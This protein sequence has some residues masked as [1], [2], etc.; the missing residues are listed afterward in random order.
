MTHIIRRAPPNAVGLET[1]LLVHGLPRA[2]SHALAQRLARTIGE[3]GSTA[4]V[5]AIVSGQP[6][7]GLNE[8]ELGA[9]LDAQAV[10]K[11]STANL[12]VTIHRRAH[13]ATTVS[14]TVELAA[15]AGLRIIATGGIGGVHPGHAATID[16][17]ADLAAIARYPVAVVCSGVKTLLDVVSTRELLETLGV[18]VIG[19]G[20]DR[21]PAFYLRDGGCDV[22][23]RFDE[24]GD[25]ARFIAF[26]L[27]RTGRGILIAQP[28]PQTHEIAP[29]AMNA[30]MHEATQRAAAAGI[31]GRSLTPFILT[32][33]HE[34]SAGATLAANLALVESN[35]KLAA[36]IS[37]RQ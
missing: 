9:L 16:I 3:Q 18:P 1:T 15:R 13:G 33:L 28:V 25:L 30:W 19:F 12:G 10:D 35:A 14:A 37:A 24:A 2:E 36:A 31:A 11:V 32:Q 26:E 23:A 22:D 7:I 29:H 6:I 21:F 8:E 17:S 27:A 20:T 5:I 34:V 4:A